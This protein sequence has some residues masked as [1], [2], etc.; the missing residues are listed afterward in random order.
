M[1]I[2]GF[3]TLALVLLGSLALNGLLIYILRSSQPPTTR[4]AGERKCAEG[5][6]LPP[7]WKKDAIAL[8]SEWLD[9]AV[10][11]D[12]GTYQLL[13]PSDPTLDSFH[14][15]KANKPFVSYAKGFGINLIQEYANGKVTPYLTV[16]DWDESGVFRRLNYG[17]V[18]DTGEIIGDVLDERMN[19]QTKI[20]KFSAG[21]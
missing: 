5:P 9:R 11:C 6:A 8:D 15:L 17:L 16:Q 1:K 13:L 2:V 4:L 12:F 10:Y 14:L 7:G 3:A 18:D 19:G 20:T 21:R